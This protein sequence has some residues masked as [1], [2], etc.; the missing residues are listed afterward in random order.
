MDIVAQ[1]VCVADMQVKKII[2]PLPLTMDGTCVRKARTHTHT[3]SE[4]H[5]E[6]LKWNVSYVQNNNV[7]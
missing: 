4:L 2:E 3:C 7:T 6:L 1:A 5:F